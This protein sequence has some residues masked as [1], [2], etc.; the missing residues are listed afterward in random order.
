MAITRWDP[1]GEMMS[2]Q[3]EMD[4]LFGRMGAPRRGDGGEMQWMPRIEAKKV[5]DDLVVRAELPG[6]KP[7]DV[8]ISVEDNVLTIK[9]ERKAEAKKAEEDYIIR[10]FSYGS[11][12]RSMVLPEGVKPE[13]IK[14]SYDNGVLTV[15]VP[16]AMEEA[17][18]RATKIP[19][20][21]GTK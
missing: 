17:K 1:F 8:D 9:G 4:R 7:E 16:K 13:D 6:L 15:S 2:W 14:A 20:G 18:P 11:F 19:V 12:E 21:A 3:K 10:E 5:G